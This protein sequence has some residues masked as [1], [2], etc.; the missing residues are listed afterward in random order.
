MAPS[1]RQGQET[2]HGLQRAN[3]PSRALQRPRPRALCSPDPSRP[4]PGAEGAGARG[5]APGRRDA[6]CVPPPA[7]AP[8]ASVSVANRAGACAWRVRGWGAREGGKGR[9]PPNSRVPSSLPVGTRAKNRP[10]RRE[11][12]ERESAATK[13]GRGALACVPPL[14]LRAPNAPRFVWG[15][16]GSETAG[17]GF[18]TRRLFTNT[19]GCRMRLLR[20]E[21]G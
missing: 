1:R 16:G 10:R 19:V 6:P 4:A 2:R 15:W 5:V 11:K 18:G 21:V 3:M 14:G 20:F 17:R 9:R 13:E 8:L 12:G 7:P